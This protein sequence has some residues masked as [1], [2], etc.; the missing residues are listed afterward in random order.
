MGYFI[1]QKY[2]SLPLFILVSTN[3]LNIVLDLVFIVGL[4][5]TSDGAALASVLAEYAGLALGIWLLRARLKRLGGRLI[6]AHLT[7]WN[8]YRP[9]LQVNRHL[10]VRTQIGRASCRERV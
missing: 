4:G 8:D 7:R 1:V 9:L 2:S 10:F 6:R 5:L 3:L